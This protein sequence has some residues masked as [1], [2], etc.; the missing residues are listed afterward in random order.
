[1]KCTS[2]SWKEAHEMTRKLY[3]KIKAK[4][5]RPDII[6]ALARGGLI[7]ARE[8]ADYLRVKDMET[9][10]VDHWGLSATKSGKAEIRKRVGLD[11]TGKKVLVVDDISDTGE[12]LKITLSYLKQLEPA[13]LKTA[14]LHL[15][16]GSISKPDFY[17]E[18]V[19]H[20]LW[21]LYPWET[22]EDLTMF[23]TKIINDEWKTANQIANE[24]KRERGIKLTRKE[25]NEIL[26]DMKHW[27]FIK[28]KKNLWK[29]STVWV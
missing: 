15:R 26:E 2:M 3:E 13:K 12:S 23:I 1:M 9:V 19:R 18:K 17:V 29:A 28:S 27:K 14:C 24:L 22:M 10:N 25:L 4:K 11:I 5:Y 8:L 6:I 20:K 16:E 7:P 21:I